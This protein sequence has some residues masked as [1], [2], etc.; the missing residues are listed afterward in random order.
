MDVSLINK[1]VTNLDAFYYWVIIAL[2]T[3]IHLLTGIERN[4]LN[5]PVNSK[6]IFRGDFIHTGGGYAADN[7]RL[8]ISI[9]SVFYPSSDSVHF[10]N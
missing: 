7:A 1:R 8:F 2:Q 10:V 5:I 9:S 6:V 4:R 3:D